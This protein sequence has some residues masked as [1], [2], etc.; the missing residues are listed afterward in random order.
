MDGWDARRD[1]EGTAIGEPFRK[2]LLELQ[3]ADSLVLGLGFPSEAGVWPLI[4]LILTCMALR[5][6]S[7]TI[8]KVFGT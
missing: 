8:P 2:T 5:N 7:T 6:C 1:A 3:V 4:L